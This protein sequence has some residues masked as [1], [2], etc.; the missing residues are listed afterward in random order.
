MGISIVSSLQDFTYRPSN[1]A[2]RVSFLVW[3]LEP[4]FSQF[5]IQNQPC[6]SESQLP[7]FLIT[8]IARSILIA[9]HFTI[10]LTSLHMCF[11]IL[12]HRASPIDFPL[13]HACNMKL[14]ARTAYSYRIVGYPMPCV[15]VWYT[16][17]FSFC[18]LSFMCS[19]LFRLLLDFNIDF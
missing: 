3:F 5:S 1:L 11:S 13:C 17:D 14:L 16:Y 8:S 6:H 7:I 9:S 15:L 18:T 12:R 19:L 4:F 10:L 2:F